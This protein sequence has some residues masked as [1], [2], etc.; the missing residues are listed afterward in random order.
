MKPLTSFS[1]GDYLGTK[2]LL[3]LTPVV[4]V[5]LAVVPPLLRWASGDP[6]LVQGGTS[7]PGPVIDEPTPG[8]VG[9]WTDAAEWAVADPTSGQRLVALLPALVVAVLLAAAVVILWRFVTT[10]QRGEPFDRRSV[11]QLQ[12]LG[13]LVLAYGLVDAFAPPAVLLAVFS[14][15]SGPS[16]AYVFDL[17]TAFPFVVGFLVLV[18]SESFRVGLALRDDVEGLV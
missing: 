8:V 10:T 7:A 18:L 9:R 17:T 3:L 11:R 15:G 1:R 4:Y 16:I 13:V 5:A 12:I 2:V 14:S 6:L